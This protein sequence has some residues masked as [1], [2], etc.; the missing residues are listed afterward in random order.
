M[1]VYDLAW[2]PAGDFIIAGSTDNTARIFATADG[3]F[4]SSNKQHSLTFI[5]IR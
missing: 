5:I 1:Q 4:C 2:S 3:A